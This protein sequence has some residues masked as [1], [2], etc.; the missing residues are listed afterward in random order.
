M[1][2]FSAARAAPLGFA[3]RMWAFFAG[4][5]VLGGVAVPFFPLWLDGRGLTDVEIANCIAIPALVRVFL[6]P[7]AGM[8]ADRAPNR[9]FAVVA[10]TVPALIIYLFAW[11]A[12]GYW[13]ILLITG[14]AFTLWGL[15]LPVAEALAL[16]GVRR[17]GM[18]YGRVRLGGSLAFIITNLGSGALLGFLD[19]EAIFWFIAVALFTSVI[20]S[21]SL[22]VTPPAVRAL[23]DVS[24][25]KPPSARAVLGHPGFLALILVGALIQSSHAVLYSFGSIYWGTLG[26][27]GFDI[28]TF[29]AIGIVIEI[30]LFSFST[31][32]IRAVGPFGLLVLGAL[33]AIVRWALFAEDLGFLGFAALQALHGLTFGA[34][35]VGNQHAIARTV[36]EEMTASAQGLFGMV[37][38]LLMAGTT[39]LAGPLYASFGADAFL[40]MIVPPVLALLI[41]VAYRFLTR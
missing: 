22:P 15:A 39:F 13:P 28:G 16:T 32:A 11:P 27:S 35:Y 37:T 10:F 38:G 30:L 1:S 14:A 29:W 24:R 31:A 23:D 26:F 40:V 25:P 2:P 3:V 6:T 33:A 7:L 17:F 12:E 36:P 5:F 21:L 8:F 19:V 34:T 4:Y 18:D 9:R 20:V 41:L